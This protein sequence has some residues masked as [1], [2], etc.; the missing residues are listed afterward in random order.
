[1][2][3]CSQ[4]EAGGEGSLRLTPRAFSRGKQCR[5]N[6]AAL[7]ACSSWRSRERTRRRAGLCHPED[8]QSNKS[9]ERYRGEQP[10]VAARQPQRRPALLSFLELHRLRQ[11]RPPLLIEFTRAVARAVARA[12][13]KAVLP[14]AVTLA[15]AVCILRAEARPASQG[16]SREDCR[17]G[18]EGDRPAPP[19]SHRHCRYSS[20]GGGIAH[21]RTN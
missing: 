15:R 20:L 14:R 3:I 2:S 6:K 4:M 11:E 18:R 19:I 10:C 21:T 13:A 12:L 17:G 5:C 8:K 16:L 9:S 1:M 7:A